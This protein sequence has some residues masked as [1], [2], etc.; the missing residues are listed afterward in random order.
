MYFAS[1]VKWSLQ[2]IWSPFPSQKF[3]LFPVTLL[4]KK[5]RLL[6]RRKNKIVFANQPVFPFDKCPTTTFH[7]ST[8]T[9]NLSNSFQ[10]SNQTLYCISSYK[11]DNLSRLLTVLLLSRYSC[12]TCLF[13]SLLARIE[14]YDIQICVQ[15]FYF[16]NVMNSYIVKHNHLCALCLLFTFKHV[17]CWKT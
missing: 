14:V 16:V 6:P 8:V 7:F 1:P 5:F 17:G 10:G 3:T 15:T 13:F 2:G 12:M 9:A 4:L 11:H